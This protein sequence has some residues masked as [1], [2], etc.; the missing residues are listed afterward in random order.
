MEGN[1]KIKEMEQY[2]LHKLVTIEGSLVDDPEI[3][4]V[5]NT[6]QATVKEVSE[7]LITAKE[8]EIKINI[9]RL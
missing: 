9:A 7:M 8:A 4:E 6:T 1:R 2:L 5:L 3:E